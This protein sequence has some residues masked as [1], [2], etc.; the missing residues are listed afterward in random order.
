MAKG[1]KGGNF[2]RTISEKLSIWFTDGE[3]SVAFWRTA[4]S[5]GRATS[6]RKGKKET[7]LEDFGDIKADAPIGKPLID[8]FS[9]E[10][11]TGY[12]KKTK[13]KAKK[14][15]GKEVTKVVNWDLLDYL[16]S[17]QKQTQFAAFWE[18]AQLD[19]TNSNREPLLIFR[20]NNKQPCIAMYTDIFHAFIGKCLFPNFDYLSMHFCKD[21]KCFPSITVCNLYEFFE[22]SQGKVKP[23]LNG[24]GNYTCTFIDFNLKR[25][26]FRR[27]RGK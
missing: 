21:E 13:S 6:R 15:G 8:F 18:Q 4:G 17:T 14:Y 23:K 1:A 9:I 11:K 19:A 5:G 27:N 25:T 20:R 16:D 7:N 10:L 3:S 12:A 2:E 24:D 26:L 22:W